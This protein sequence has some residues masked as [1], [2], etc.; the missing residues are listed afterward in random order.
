MRVI[1]SL[2]ERKPRMVQEQKNEMQRGELDDVNSFKRGFT[3]G[4]LSEETLFLWVKAAKESNGRAKLLAG[5]PRVDL[6]HC[7]VEVHPCTSFL[8]SFDDP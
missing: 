3:E 6:P 5:A 1:F 4:R 7:T 2:K 8:I